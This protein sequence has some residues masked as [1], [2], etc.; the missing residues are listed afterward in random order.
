MAEPIRPPDLSAGGAAEAVGEPGSVPRGSVSVVYL[1][2]DDEIPVVARRIRD[3]T[4][5]RVVLVA[6]PRARA[7]SGGVAIRLLARLAAQAGR[8]LVLVGDAG[9]RARAAD[10]GVESHPSLASVPG[11]GDASANGPAREG[12]DAASG[13]TPTD[14]AVADETAPVR[15]RIKVVRGVASSDAPT[16]PV[17]IAP[18]R[19]AAAQP[20]AEQRPREQRQRASAARRLPAPPMAVVA[21]GLAGLLL[22]GAAGAAAIVLPSAQ[23]TI[24][25]QARP[26]GPV[27]YRLAFPA[28]EQVASGSLT[29]SGVP[30]GERIEL[31]TAAGSVAFSNWNTVPVEV[32]A[33]TRVLAG[34]VAF[35]TTHAVV[36]PAGQLS[37]TDPPIRPG[38]QLAEVVAVEA[39]PGGNVA[40]GEIDTVESQPARNRL[41]GF[42][43]NQGRLVANPEP[44][45]GGS[46]TSIPV[47][48]ADDVAA[49]EADLRSAIAQQ[50]RAELGAHADRLYVPLADD[51]LRVEI[52]GAD[53]LVGREGLERFELTASYE[54][55]YRYVPRE[56]VEREAHERFAAD[57]EALPSGYEVVGDSVSVRLGERRLEDGSVVLDVT[58]SAQAAPQI[59]TELLLPRLAGTTPER[60]QALL[61]PYGDARVSLWPGW[62]ETVPTLDWRVSI[63]LAPVRTLDR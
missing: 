23:I 15:T 31:G 1:E 63:S 9:V 59:D 2:P 4:A 35:E 45:A 54:V 38:H 24:T 36:V 46:E 33:G 5:E 44:T 18:F 56:T 53:E 27:D 25:P 61:A 51:D 3:E 58:V 22:A 13:P 37:F 16:A 19:A 48:T 8:Q 49:V 50:A 6:P 29:G 11:L 34:D 40:T 42:A 14:A 21:V 52:S 7:T 28:T 39:G 26:V 43:N 60:A 57:P 30:T 12:R 55:S 47:V 20:A 10:A 41:R 62:V 17:A 32:P